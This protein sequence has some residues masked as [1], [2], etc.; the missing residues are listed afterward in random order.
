MIHESPE[1]KSNIVDKIKLHEYSKKILGKDICVP[2][3]K[4]YNHINKIKLKDL[5][6]KFVLKL[7]HGSEMNIICN[8]KS[9]LNMSKVEKL[10]REWKH[11]NYGL[12]NAEFQYMFVQKKI[13]AEQYLGNNLIDYK[14]FCFNGIPKFIRIRKF[15]PGSET[16]IHNHYD[17]NWKLNDIES[18]LTGYIRDPNVKV[19]KPRNLELMLKY[20]KKLSKEFVFL[21][22]D[23]YEVNNTIYLGELTF[24][25]SNSFIKWKNLEQ[26][27]IIG[28]LMDLTKIKKYLYNK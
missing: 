16:K 21:R 7:N 4:I 12:R 13:Y 15:L 14:I 17:T 2:I 20:A 27:I 3:I 1:Y 26:N 18:G 9:D 23:L 28:N 25:P 19:K 8:N 11:Q 10:L 22:V 24:S 6:N 5:P